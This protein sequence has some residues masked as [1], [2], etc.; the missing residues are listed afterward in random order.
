MR[1]NDRAISVDADSCIEMRRRTVEPANNAN[2]NC[3][4]STIPVVTYTNDIHYQH[5]M[6]DE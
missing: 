2:K 1:H 3:H 6:S 4:I 5:N